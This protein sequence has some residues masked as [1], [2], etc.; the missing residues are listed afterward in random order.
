MMTTVNGYAHL[1]FD[2]QY[3]LQSHDITAMGYTPGEQYFLP[4]PAAI[5]GK[6]LG[7]ALA[8]SLINSMVIMVQLGIPCQLISCRHQEDHEAEEILRHHN[9]Q[10]HLALSTQATGE[11]NILIDEHGERTMLACVGAA[12]EL[13]ASQLRKDAALQLLE[14]YLAN[15]QTGAELLVAAKDLP[16]A[17]TLGHH[18]LVQQHLALFQQLYD[19]KPRYL[20]G[21]LAEFN[22]LLGTNNI[23]DVINRVQQDGIT[24]LISN[25]QHGAVSVVDG[26]HYEQAAMAVAVQDTTGAGDALAGAWLAAC[27]SGASPQSALRAAV[28][29][30][31]KVVSQVGPRLASNHVEH[32]VA[33]LRE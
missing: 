12:S 24:A 11:C 2:Q 7:R 32:V 1:L 6:Q 14:G 25:G 8:G 9:L 33:L 15:F 16:F 27:L 22:A 19:A 28:Y 13:Q 18:G 17:L 26:E 31:A 4:T 29:A 3:K 21:N 20:M 30:A 10:H 5:P 23:N